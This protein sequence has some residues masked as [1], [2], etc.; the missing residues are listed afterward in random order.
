MLTLVTPKQACYHVIIKER[1][2]ILVCGIENARRKMLSINYCVDAAG[3]F[4][5]V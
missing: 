5:L 4:I 2:M 1:M 3:S